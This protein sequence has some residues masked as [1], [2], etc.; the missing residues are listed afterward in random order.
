MDLSLPELQRTLAAVDGVYKHVHC[1]GLLGTYDDGLAWLKGPENL[2]KPKCVLWMGSSIGNLNRTDAAAF[3]KGFS[4]VLGAQ[5]TML[6]GI[7][8]CQDTD[9]VFH[10]YNDKEGKTHEF[11][12]NGLT[13]ANRL[14]G[15]ELFHKDDWRVT[16]E[17][18]V[19]AG[20]H[21]AF[22][23]P[24]RNV[25]VDGMQIKAGER[26]R[27]EESYKYSLLQSTD[28]WRNAGLVPQARFGDRIDQYRESLLQH[29]PSSNGL[30]SFAPSIQVMS[31]SS[32]QKSLGRF[33]SLLN[34]FQF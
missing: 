14:L 1:H 25:M 3:L 28:L 21:Q 5:D 30:P 29:G 10:A 16:G 23:S 12:L 2:E 15:R 18:D 7:D 11:V 4:A 33:H 26:V 32:V 6:I 27:I 9:K 34:P 20:R 22:V 13:H 17:Y 31:T 8:A 24:V 19:E